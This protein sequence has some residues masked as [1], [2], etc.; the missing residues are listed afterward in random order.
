MLMMHEWM[1]W[2]MVLIGIFTALLLVA[3][4]A[5]AIW[6]ANRITPHRNNLGG[7]PGDF[8]RERYARGEIDRDEYQRML[9]DLRK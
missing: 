5:I 3:A 8:V 6:A 9:Q 2:W 1:S 7:D 4:L